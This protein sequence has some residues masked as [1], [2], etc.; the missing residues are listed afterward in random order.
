[1]CS[2][3]NTVHHSF[4]QRY[5]FEEPTQKDPAGTC[6]FKL[7]RAGDKRSR[8]AASRSLSMERETFHVE[9]IRAFQSDIYGQQVFHVEHKT[10]FAQKSE[11]LT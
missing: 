7:A 8:L 2:T 6:R 9:H 10:N 1:M 3:W 4:P 5:S 11:P